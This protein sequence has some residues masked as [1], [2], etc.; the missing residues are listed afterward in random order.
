M[1]VCTVTHRNILR[2]H[3]YVKFY[4]FALTKFKLFDIKNFIFFGHKTCTVR[5]TNKKK[6]KK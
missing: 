1:D 6:K 3:F 2:T 4:S 5:S